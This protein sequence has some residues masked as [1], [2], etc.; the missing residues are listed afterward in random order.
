MNWESIV[1]KVID[2]PYL[3]PLIFIMFV[4]VSFATYIARHVEREAKKTSV[5]IKSQRKLDDISSDRINETVIIAHSHDKINEIRDRLVE[6]VHHW[7]KEKNTINKETDEELA[8][9]QDA[10]NK[11]LFEFFKM[12]KFK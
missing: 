3:V 9:I 4:F 2:F 6:N 8:K 5:I 7:Q 10:K 11:P 12:F 1:I